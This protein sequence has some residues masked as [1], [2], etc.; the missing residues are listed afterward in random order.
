MLIVL[1][2]LALAADTAQ[3]YVLTLV[4]MWQTGTD[5]TLLKA[6]A[7][8]MPDPLST[9][10]FYCL[11][12]VGFPSALLVGIPVA[13][14]S[15]PAGLECK[16]FLGIQST[17]SPKTPVPPPAPAPAPVPAPAPAP[18]PTTV[19][20]FFSWE[21]EPP[22]P[23][24]ASPPVAPVAPPTPPAPVAPPPVAPPT[25]PPVTPP[26]VAVPQAASPAAMRAYRAD[27]L[28]LG[29]IQVTTSTYL[30]NPQG[31]GTVLV[32]TGDWN[33]VLKGGEQR[34]DPQ[35]FAQLVHDTGTV[36]KI[37]QI[38]TVS[39]AAGTLG[40][41]GTFGGLAMIANSTEMQDIKQGFGISMAG[42]VVAVGGAG[43][44]YCTKAYKLYYSNNQ[45]QS[46]VDAY[47]TELR[48]NLGLTEQDTVEIDMK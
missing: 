31:G 18:P 39:I 36:T 34:L 3:N 26:P 29:T 6:V 21:V 27:Y 1:L 28:R 7:A 12:Q 15:L 41:I 2:S 20:G 44:F 45:I 4:N 38:K 19:S 42:L 32:G 25:A 40:L 9:A 46:K 47:N 13:G 10:E 30:A 24:T 48:S 17:L 5:T 37:K 43:G 33:G 8:R 14:G 35:D 22:K 16:A 11:Q 23:A